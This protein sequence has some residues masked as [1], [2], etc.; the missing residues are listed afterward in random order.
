MTHGAPSIAAWSVISPFGLDQHQFRAGVAT[1]VRA[2]VP[3]PAQ[4]GTVPA[5]HACLVPDFD[6]RAVLGR[7]GT[8][9]MDRLSGLVVT[10]V[11]DLLTTVGE[12]DDPEATAVVLATHGSVQ[13]MWQPTRD[14]LLAERPFYIDPASVPRSVMNCAASEAARWHGLRGPNATVASGRTSGLLALDYAR[15]LLASG[16]ATQVLV[17][18]AEEYSAAR[19]W[20]E[21]HAYGTELLGEGCVMFLLEAAQGEDEGYSPL[22]ELLGVQCRAHDHGDVAELLRD[23]LVEILDRY[24]VSA[25]QLWV[26]CPSLLHGPLGDE[27]RAG[28]EAVVGSTDARWITPT[29]VLGETTV[30]TA[31]FQL[32][33]VLAAADLAPCPDVRFAVVTS[34]DPEGTLACALLRVVAT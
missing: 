20:L 26:V 12:L 33:A 16:R 25:D 1:G 14:S 29:T 15:R 27:E 21:F 6:V 8:R 10:A 3:V 34:V 17:G 9:T 22:A 28:L 7:K 32:A 5:D 11:R 30:A 23:C 4:H 2:A 13:S 24:S 18:A 19:A 31:A